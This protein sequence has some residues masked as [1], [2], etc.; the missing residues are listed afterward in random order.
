MRTKLVTLAFACLAATACR[1]DMHDQPRYEPLQPAEIFA[2]GRSAR[3]LPAHT[4]A[5]GTLN[6]T[7]PEFTG[8]DASGGFL[9]TIPM[10]LDKAL[11]NRGRERYEI[12]C[13]P[14][15]GMAGDAQGMVAL[16]GFRAPPS[17]HS[18]RARRLPPG[19][20]F[21]VITNGFLGMPDYSDQIA[22][23]DRWAIVAYV[24]ALQLSAQASEADVPAD[25]RA[26]L[27]RAQ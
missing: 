9:G 7:Q 12:Y 20:V 18:D 14:C 16:R 13:S 10:P 25:R 6:D 8:M 5:R 19:Y 24:M 2:D 3:P 22:V 15:H 4:V 23:R 17:L 27:E 21:A 1:Q 26:E 11:V